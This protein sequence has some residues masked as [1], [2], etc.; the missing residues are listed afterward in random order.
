MWVGFPRLS[1]VSDSKDKTVKKM[2]KW[3]DGI[4]CWK[5]PRM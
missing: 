1:L 3:K 5:I 2:R 4:W